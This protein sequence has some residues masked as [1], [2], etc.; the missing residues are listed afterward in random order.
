MSIACVSVLNP[1]KR[2]PRAEPL[3]NFF[4]RSGQR[5]SLAPQGAA[6]SPVSALGG[7]HWAV[8][9]ARQR[10]EKRAVVPDLVR[11]IVVDGTAKL[12]VGD[13]GGA[14][15]HD[16]VYAGALCDGEVAPAQGRDQRALTV[17]NVHQQAVAPHRV[18]VR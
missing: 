18:E 1:S 15:E 17:C 10:P 3:V 7:E 11:A 6:P 14:A 13:A 8:R 5:T 2:F 9:R 16:D 12:A 4:Q